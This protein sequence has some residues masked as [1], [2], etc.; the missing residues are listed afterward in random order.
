MLPEEK[1][2]QPVDFPESNSVV[3]GQS[4]EVGDLPVWKGRHP[5][6]HHVYISA[7][8]FGLWERLKLLF[9]GRIYL[10]LISGLQ[11]PAWISLTAFVDE[12]DDRGQEPP[13]D[14][15]RQPEGLKVVD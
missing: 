3:T 4:S 1:P 10:G 6:G 8:E 15:V 2:A 5:N 14:I 11:P 12:D 13:S 7:W 9:T